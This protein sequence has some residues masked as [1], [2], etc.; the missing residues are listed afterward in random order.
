MGDILEPSLG[1]GSDATTH[2][3]DGHLLVIQQVRAL[4]DNAKRALA[5]FLADA[6]VHAHHVGG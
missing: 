5:Y 4:E 1:P 3:F 6:V 2:E